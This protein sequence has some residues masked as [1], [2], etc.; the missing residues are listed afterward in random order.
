MNS[1]FLKKLVPHLIAAGIFLVVAVF[2]CSP[3]L[4]GKV[5]NQHDIVGWKGMAQQSFE[6]KEKYGHFPLWTNSMFS[7]M[8]AYT[9]AMD[10]KYPVS[11]GFVYHLARL[12]L[13]IPIGYFFV[14]CV[15]F[16]F[17]C[18]V[19]RVRPW[20]SVMA[21]IA[22]AYSTYDPV[23]IAVGHNTKMQAIALAPAVIGS[24]LLLFQRK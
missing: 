13:P 14:A 6:Y 7:G 17:L 11:V 1:S 2:Y 22:F 8:P 16:Y 10:Q 21:A 12:G 5:V 18:Q 23:I 4:Q 15:C 19:L 9:I 3:A 20:L 24:F